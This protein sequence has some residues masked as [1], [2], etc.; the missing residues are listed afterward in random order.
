MDLGITTAM[1]TPTQD[2]KG[3][4]IL[5]ILAGYY[6]LGA[7]TQMTLNGVWLA[8]QLGKKP[9]I[10]WGKHCFYRTADGSDA[11]DK[12]FVIRTEPIA[13]DQVLAESG[14]AVYPQEW[15]GLKVPLTIEAIEEKIDQ[16]NGYLMLNWKKQ[17]YE[18]MMKADLCVLN[19]FLTPD[20]AWEIAGRPMVDYDEN[21]FNTEA[22]ELFRTHFQ[23]VREVTNM[24]EKLWRDNFRVNHPVVGT[25]LRGSD[26]ITDSALP[27]PRNLVKSARKMGRT[28]KTK[29]FFLATD[30][31]RGMRI[32]KENIGPMDTFF[33]QSFT[34]S[35]GTE[36]LHYVTQNGVQQ[37]RETMIDVEM[38]AQCSGFVGFPGSLI[39]WWVMRLRESRKQTFPVIGIGPNA[40]DYVVCLYR[41]FVHKNMHIF[42]TFLRQQKNKV[43]KKLKGEWRVK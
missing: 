24:V 13:R 36:G 15:E 21:R 9:V 17:H 10:W 29:D 4:G 25:H 42:M 38:L 32:F 19:C 30:S 35:K 43:Q 6:G 12:L 11:F 20:L 3:Q 18:E 34:R 23:P 14:A 22:C 5:L 8:E 31:E 40:I 27:N 16:D 2:A 26:K 33:A 41:L 1:S 28:L 37:A 7:L 39:Y